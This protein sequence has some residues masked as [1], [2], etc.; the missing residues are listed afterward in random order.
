ML[1]QHRGLDQT[2]VKGAGSMRNGGLIE[3][4]LILALSV[5]VMQSD[6][7]AQAP[8]SAF[9]NESVYAGPNGMISIQFDHGARLL[10]AEKQG[11][12][13]RFEPNGSGGYQA[14]P[15][16]F[17]DFTSEV[18]PALESGL[19]GFALDPDYATNR[20]FY[21]GYTTDHDQRV[22]RMQANA[23]FTAVEPDSAL[24]LLS[25]LP[26]Q[27]SFHKAGDLR[28]SPADPTALYMALGDDGD[29]N[30]VQDPD[31]YEGKILRF[32]AATGLGMPDNPFYNGDPASVRSR[33]FATGLRNP[34]RI[35]FNPAQPS[36]TVLYSSENGD[37][38]DRLSRISRGSNGAWGPG[39]DGGGFLDPPDPDHQVLFTGPPSHIGLAISPTG[40]FGTN[41]LYLGKWFPGTPVIRRFQLTGA[42]L[43]SATS[44]DSGVFINNEVAVDMQFGPDGHLYYSQTGGD[45]ST[46]G[47]YQ[48]KRIRFVGGNPPL[49]AFS[50]T[51]NPAF[52]SAPLLVDFTD[53][54]SAP[55]SS[56][57]S[58]TWDFGD[59][60][61]STLSDPQHSYAVPGV[62]QVRLTVTN[63]LGQ[64][65][66]ET[67]SIRATRAVNLHVQLS[68]RDGRSLAAPVLASATELRFYEGDGVTPLAVSGGSGPD[69]NVRSVAAGGVV[70]FSLS[71]NVPGQTL[72]LSAGEAAADGVQAA[73]RGY[74]LPVGSGPHL[75]D[76]DFILSDTLLTGRV[77]DTAD[78][79][80]A[81]DV[82]LAL[83]APPLP[84][85][86]PQGRDFLPASQIP[87]SGV[88]HRKLSDALGYFHFPLRTGNSGA[89]RVDAVADT[90]TSTHAR[91]SIQQQLAVA[92]VEDLLV[93]VGRWSGGSDCDDLSAIEVAPGV[94]YDTQIQPIWS[95]ACIGCHVATSAN[96]G[97]LDL[98][99]GASLDQLRSRLSV[100]APGVPLLTEG[101]TA[102]SY[103]F[104]KI[105]CDAPQAGTR[106]R[107]ANPMPLPQQTLIRDWITQQGVLFSDGFEIK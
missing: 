87:P 22:V 55:G 61:G 54:S 70:N 38:T 74:L 40:P 3:K 77:L 41:V 67:R 10:V 16:V 88:A 31:R 11:R 36:T 103:L 28:F 56:I 99:S 33:V 105:N 2:F 97:G 82:G 8:P 12:I 63:A 79:P 94:D 32:D 69:F 84:Y 91:A 85:P 58:R 19:L 65:A 27:A 39:G 73:R 30:P 42:A 93:R 53:Q 92:T 21:V 59:G 51:P 5:G 46:G 48:L 86:T 76:G 104:E 15:L 72:V 23:G 89:L 81:V 44:L 4:G 78:T 75:L 18:N 66:S 17:A 60:N 29:R 101:N 24:V 6:L 37:A 96:N 52:G 13:M 34:F 98:T 83:G 7:A 45:A 64:S 14:P 49:A 71:V 102:R 106:M 20:Y 95:G 80:L 1:Q 43:D 9:V 26:R 50:T 25:G 57:S 90:G 47:F 107:P 100:Q 68:V 35:T 62:Y